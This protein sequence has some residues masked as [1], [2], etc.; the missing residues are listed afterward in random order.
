MDFVGFLDDL[1][2]CEKMDCK[3]PKLLCELCHNQGDIDKV[4]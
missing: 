4:P 1:E 3:L 2:S